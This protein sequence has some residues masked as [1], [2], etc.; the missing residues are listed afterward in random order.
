[1]KGTQPAA[2]PTATSRGG[3][4]LNVRRNKFFMNT[5]R[6][7]G[8]FGVLVA[9]VTATIGF[10]SP[11]TMEQALDY[12]NSV[13]LLK[14]VVKDNKIHAYVKEVWRF[15]PNA[16]PPPAVGAEYREPMPNDP[17]NQFPERDGIAFTFGKGRP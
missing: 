9:L 12:A 6:L 2:E 14:R 17:R 15:D 10:G 3:L 4:I 5:Q 13:V 1:M 7:R 16:G 8:M 11:P